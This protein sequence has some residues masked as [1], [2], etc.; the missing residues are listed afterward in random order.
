MNLVNNAVEAIVAAPDF[1]EKLKKF[2]SIGGEIVID[3]SIQDEK[4]I[5]TLSDSGPGISNSDLEYIFD[6]FFTR[7]K[8]MGL[9]VGLS[10]CYGIIEDHQGTITAENSPHSGVVFTINLP[11]G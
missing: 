8:K 4:I 6:P 11:L 10:I 9:G 7:K 5:I 1:E 2:S 3:T